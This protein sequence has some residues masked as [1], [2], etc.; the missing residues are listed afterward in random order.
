M[1]WADAPCW[2]KGGIGAGLFTSIT[3]VLILFTLLIL[4]E[5]PI[6]QGGMLEGLV[7]QPDW[8]MLLIGGIT[9]LIIFIITF[10]LGAGIGILYAKIKGIK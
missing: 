9:V 6:S 1:G 2:L 7:G 3:Y 5:G 10:I 8:V 4:D